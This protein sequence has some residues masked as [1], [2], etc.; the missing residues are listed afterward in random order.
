MGMQTVRFAAPPRV[1]REAAAFVFGGPSVVSALTT[2]SVDE[3]A[4]GQYCTSC[5]S[6][7]NLTLQGSMEVLLTQRELSTSTSERR[8][9]KESEFR[10]LAEQSPMRLLWLIRYGNLRPAQ[11]TFAAEIAG[12]IAD[13]AIVVPALLELLNHSSPVVREGAVYGLEKHLTT[14]VRER[15]RLVS[16]K[17]PSPAVRSAA[18]DAIE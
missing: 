6:S 8:D 12:S 13:S 3:E 7:W 14:E 16:E 9:P 2:A 11:L 10:M 1:Q 18:R 4:A 17:D 15:L 5:E